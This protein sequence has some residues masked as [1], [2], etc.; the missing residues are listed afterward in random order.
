MSEQQIPTPEPRGRAID[1]W[2]RPFLVFGLLYFA[3]AYALAYVASRVGFIESQWVAL[4]TVSIATAIAVAMFDRGRWPIG[5]SGPP[6]AATR[7]LLFG[8]IFAALLIGVA[9]RIIA[10]LANLHHTR[11]A[12][13]PWRELVAV[14]IP[15]AIHEE[16]LFRGYAYQK[17]RR[18]SRGAAVAVLSLLFAIAHAGNQGMTPLALAN[19]IIAGVLLAL[20]YELYERLWFPIGLHLAWNVVSGP[21]I[22][23]PVSGF[24]TVPTVFITHVSGLPFVTGGAFGIEGSIGVTVAEL[25]AI[26]WLLSRMY[27]SRANQAQQENP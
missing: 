27:H 3:V 19:L 10:L 13:F 25:C 8:C 7:E 15:A 12:G 26:S 5:F 2:L 24:V 18:W 6:V 16:L 23:Y 22:G 9:D 1:R 21:L 14:Y 4:A 11:G 20:A 17:M